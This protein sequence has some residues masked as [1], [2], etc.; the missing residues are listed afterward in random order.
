MG[1]N[2][3]QTELGVIAKLENCLSEEDI[4]R[5]TSYRRNIFFDPLTYNV[6]EKTK[7]LFQNDVMGTPLFLV[8]YDM[9]R[10]ILIRDEDFVEKFFESEDE[11]ISNE[12]V[13]GFNIISICEGFLQVSNTRS[14]I[15]M[16]DAF[17]AWQEDMKFKCDEIM[18]FFETMRIFSIGNLPIVLE[19]TED[20]DRVSGLISC[21]KKI[22]KQENILFYE[23][24]H[25]LILLESSR[26]IIDLINNIFMTTSPKLIFLQL[27]R[28]LEYL[29]VINKSE[30]LSEKYGVSIQTLVGL[31]NDEKIKFAEHSQIYCLLEE[32]ASHVYISNYI[33]YF[34]EKMNYEGKE[35]KEV[36][37]V[38]RYIYET[39]CKIA[40]YKYAQEKIE[41]E[42]Y[43]MDS[44][45]ILMKLVTSVF[46]SIDTS[47]RAVN[48]HFETWELIDEI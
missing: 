41:D 37:K 16:L 10:Y 28:M 33:D 35:E 21:G 36:E 24:L 45:L 8:E 46:T 20:V 6:I 3:R 5:K 30:K 38:S 14:S 15:E 4:E 13:N 22:A 48:M 9:K 42:S 12:L 47:V 29:Y 7:C 1:R 40:H 27:Y 19:C 18:P 23:N 43:L 31:L 39:R 25:N 2:V 32:H 26:G 44:I 17:F 34:K 11:I